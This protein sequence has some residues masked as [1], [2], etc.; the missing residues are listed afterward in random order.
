MAKKTLLADPLGTVVN[1]GW[2]VAGE[3][4]SPVAWVVMLAYTLQLYLDFS[5]YC[6]IVTGAARLLGVRL[7]VNFDSPFRAL[8]VT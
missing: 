3:L 6:D 2:A 5:G 1:N 7:P 4:S 8:S